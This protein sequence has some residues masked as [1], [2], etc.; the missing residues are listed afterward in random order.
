[1]WE[2]PLTTASSL[3]VFVYACQG[4]CKSVLKVKARSTIE[5]HPQSGEGIK[6]LL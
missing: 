5:L 2:V 6:S 1:M 4:V 3:D